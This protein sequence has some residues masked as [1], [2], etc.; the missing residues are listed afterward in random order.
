MTD[1]E[2]GLKAGDEAR[3]RRAMLHVLEDLQRERDA[4]RSAHQEWISTVDAVSDPMVVRD[5]KGRIVRANRAYAERAGLGFKELIGRPYLECFPKR[6]E[7]PAA[8]AAEPGEEE[9]TLEET[10]EVFVSHVHPV[11]GADGR[12]RAW[13]H[14]FENVTRQR[15][16]RA[17]VEA[18]ERYFRKVIESSADAFFVLDRTGKLIYRSES[19]QRLTGYESGEVLGRSLTDMVDRRSLADARDALQRVLADPRHMVHAELLIGRKDGSTTEVEAVG[20]NLLA[21]PDVQGIVVTARDISARKAAERRIQRLNTLYATLSAVNHAIVQ[22]KSRK[23]ICERMVRIST[24]VGLWHGAWLGFI[25][26]ASQQ[27]RA[28]A[29][30]ESMAPYVHKLQVSV[31]PAVASG[32]GP[33]GNAVRNGVPYFCNEIRTDPATLPW[34]G[35]A[36]TFGIH[37]VASIPL[38]VAGASVGVVNLY[39]I[40]P[41]IYTPEVRELVIEM[42]DDVSFALEMLER[43]ERRRVAEEGLAEHQEKLRR[44]LEA[45]VEAIAATVET[46]DP[47]TAG[48]QRRVAD[49]ARAIGREMGLPKSVQEGLHFGALIHDLGKV[50]I[51]AEILS[52]PTRLTKLEYELIKTHSQAGY[53]IIK[54]I[55]FPWPVPAMVHQHHERLDGSGYPQGLKG[56]AIVLEARILAVA[57]VVEAMASHRP[58]RPGRGVDAALQE[59]EGKRGTWF[60]AGAVDACLRL[61]RE[62]G[63]VLPG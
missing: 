35:F 6:P 56:D 54:G 53:D 38:Q 63:F 25:D 27:I 62:K 31:D 20:H 36:D 52:K 7:R 39:S 16:A 17:A 2:L 22:S 46:R 26:P 37:T 19:A 32:Q 61:F 44:G 60:D 24:E 49:L 5:T 4:I 33:T 13:L 47:Y 30:S 43:E 11:R 40:E 21:D 48:H 12:P 28:Y 23:E 42:G 9:F 57:D 3:V 55:D 8:E 51:P 50:Q 45:T 29:W 10:G 15:Q 1:L 34:R 58:Y 41:D 59:I 18:R 14:V